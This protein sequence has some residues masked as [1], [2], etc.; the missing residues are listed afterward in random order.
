MA[1]VNYYLKDP[2]SDKGTLIYL[3][4]RYKGKT[5]KYSTGESINP[6][7]WNPNSQRAKETSKFPEY[8]D[9]NHYLNKLAERVL[10]IFRTYKANGI[11]PESN[12]LRQDLKDS[13]SDNI[14]TGNFMEVFNEFVDSKRG[15]FSKRT[16]S[17]YNDM[18]KSL[19]GFERM[20]KLN[21]S[22]DK[23]DLKFYDKYIS[24]LITQNKMV[25]N[26]V[27]KHIKILKTFLNWAS[28]HGYNSNM[29]FKKVKVHYP[30]VDTIALTHKELMNIYN[31]DLS[32]EKSMEKV[33]DAFCFGY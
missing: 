13:F 6:K 33:R 19:K 17:N 26:T 15:I 32:K 18:M 5:L 24:H 21:L 30:E 9:L 27:T 20:N 7:F 31:L 16:I 25:D 11:Y 29:D 3:M 8:P 22:F 14:S 10:N 12:Q 1:K 23:L 2:Q 28:E 4:F